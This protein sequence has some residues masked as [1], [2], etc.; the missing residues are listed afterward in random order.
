MSYLCEA[1]EIKQF[2][3]DKNI[4]LLLIEFSGH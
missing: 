4:N 2:A 3:L 1:A